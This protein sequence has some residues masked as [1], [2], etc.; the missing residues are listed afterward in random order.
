ME[1]WCKKNNCDNYVEWSYFVGD[2]IDDIPC[3]SCVLQGQSRRI[4]E[5]ASNCPYKDRDITY[6]LQEVS[7]EINKED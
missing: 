5:I 6:S 7:K 1:E 4:Q 3:I 2:D